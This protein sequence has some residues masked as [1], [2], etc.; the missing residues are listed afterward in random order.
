MAT[1]TKTP[2]AGA[3]GAAFIASMTLAPLANAAENPFQVTQLAS[4]YAL[5]EAEKAPADGKCGEAKCGAAKTDAASADAAKAKEGTCG[6]AKAKEGGCG[7]AKAAE[8]KCGEGKCGEGKCG[9]K[10]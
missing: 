7:D 2:L 8:G 4:G 5:A 10:K 3:V 1:F 6:D 9:A